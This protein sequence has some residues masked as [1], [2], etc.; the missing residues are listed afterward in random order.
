MTPSPPQSGRSTARLADDT[1]LTAR[2]DPAAVVK[3]RPTSAQDSASNDATGPADAGREPA[4]PTPPAR[5]ATRDPFA[6]PFRIWTDLATIAGEMMLAS[7]Q[8]IGHRTGRMAWTGTAPSAHDL[9]EFSLMSQEKFEAAAESSQAMSAQM[10]KM[11]Q[12]MWAQTVRQTQAGVLAMVSL[13]GSR[14]FAESIARHAELVRIMSGSTD[15]GSQFSSATARLARSGL[16][17]IHARATANAER[18]GKPSRAPET[19]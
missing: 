13:A 19:D 15:A 11:N 7:A 9:D 14:N 2:P 18:L 4:E 16:R 10:A 3:P 12:Q 1:V 6:N 5:A 8:V 17:P